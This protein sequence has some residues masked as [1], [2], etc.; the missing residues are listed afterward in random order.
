MDQ[1]RLGAVTPSLTR[2]PSRRGVLRA[3]AAAGLG[4]AV[5]WPGADAAA[6]NARNGTK[7]KKGLCRHDGSP[8]RKPGKPCKKRYCL[9]APF[10]ISATWTE[11]ADHDTYLFVPP[12][13]EATGPSP[14]LDFRCGPQTTTCEEAYPFACVD[15]DERETGDEITTIHR[16]LSGR[17][18]YWIDLYDPSPAGVVT[19]A[20]QAANGRVVGEWTSPST[21]ALDSSAWHVFDVDGR[22]GRVTAV[23]TLAEGPMPDAAHDPSTKIC[24]SG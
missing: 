20:L 2:M 5:S 4:W 16:L 14:Y 9:A 6:G 22:G 7:R 12:Q 8:C 23:D 24:P 11:T 1:N 15:G 21:A 10:T 17:Y 18:E 19:V 13:N 3:L